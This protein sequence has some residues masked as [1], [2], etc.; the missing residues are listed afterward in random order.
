MQQNTLQGYSLVSSSTDK[1]GVL[2]D[3]NNPHK[4]GYSND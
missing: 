2:S 3:D 1:Y 4:E